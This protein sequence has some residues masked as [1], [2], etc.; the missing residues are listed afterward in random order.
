MLLLL[1]CCYVVV[2]LLLLCCCY[3]VVMLSQD[4]SHNLTAHQFRN[5]QNLI[6]QLNSNFSRAYAL[7]AQSES[8]Y[9]AAR[10]QL[11]T[12]L[13]A[14]PSRVQLV[15]NALASYRREA[16]LLAESDLMDK[17]NYVHQKINDSLSS[18]Y[19]AISSAVEVGI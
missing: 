8:A 18:T 16:A 3:V 19:P 2:M 15:H 17:A 6:G 7:I 5:L 11:S 12:A 10:S 4:F 13:D 9:S 14:I 1:C